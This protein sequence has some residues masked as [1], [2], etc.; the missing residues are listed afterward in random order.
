[1]QVIPL[2]SRHEVLIAEC[3]RRF[4][5]GTNPTVS[6]SVMELQSQRVETDGVVVINEGNEAYTDNTGC[7]TTSTQSQDQQV[8][9]M[10]WG[11]FPHWAGSKMR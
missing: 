11:G 1:M 4:A 6:R 10:T 7:W 2:Q 8:G 9:L 5:Q 3:L